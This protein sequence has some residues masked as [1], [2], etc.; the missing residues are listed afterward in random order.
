MEISDQV[1][2]NL[3]PARVIHGLL[4]LVDLLLLTYAGTTLIMISYRSYLYWFQT[5]VSGLRSLTCKVCKCIY[6]RI[7]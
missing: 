1:K 2:K 5:K 6:M 7:T 4:L 3:T